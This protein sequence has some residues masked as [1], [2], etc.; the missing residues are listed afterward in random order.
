MPKGT[1]ISDEIRRQVFIAIDVEKL[2]FRKAAERFSI[3]VGSAY[4]IYR[5]GLAERDPSPVEPI[6]RPGYLPNG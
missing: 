5:D 6:S 1:R 2:S 3:S 4:S